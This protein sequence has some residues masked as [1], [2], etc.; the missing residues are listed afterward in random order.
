M[1]E[2][3][4]YG[5]ED[6]SRQ[7]CFLY[8][9]FFQED[10]YAISHDHYLDGSSSS[11]PMEHLSSNDQFS[12]LTVKRLIGQIR[13]QNHS[14]VLFVN[15]A[16]NPLADC[17][18][19]SY[20]ESV[21]EGLTLVLEVPFSIRSKYSV[22]GMN[23]WKSFRSIH[24]IFPFLEDKFPHSNY[25]SDARIP[26]SI[27]P[28]ILV[29]TFR[30]LIR[31]APSLHPLRSVLYEYRNS[32]ENLQRSIIVVPRVN[33]RFFLFLWNYYVYECESILFS[34]LKRSSHSRSLA[35]RPFPHGTHFHRKIKH[36]IIFSRRNSLKSIW[37]L[38]DPKINYVRYGE[39]SIIAIKGTHLLVKKCRYYLLL[40][41]QCYFHL[42]SE[43]YRVCSHQLSKNCSSSLG[44]FLRVRMNPLFVRTK[45]L[46]ELFIA[47]L[48]TNEFDPIVPIVP[49][50]GL[51]AREKFCDVSGRPISKLSW[52]NLTDDDILNRFDQIWR[53]LF[54]YYSGSFG[55]DGLYRIKYILS[56]SCAKTL[57]CKHK[58][59]I[60][61]VR[62]ELGPELLSKIVFK[63]TRFDSLP[64]S[65]KAAARSQRER[66]WHSD[67]PQ[68]NPLV[69]SWQKIQDLKIENL[70][71]Q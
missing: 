33:T 9:L 28:E 46:D 57:A 49:I 24:S 65:S 48:I 35:H 17:K 66:I 39:R 56:L 71:D 14:I 67:I 62:K 42:W 43:P 58:S 31:D 34:L 5:K 38:K 11:E 7:Q 53:N 19:S 36:I 52:T 30:R 10:L 27:H 6:N 22:E 8:P 37:L 21:L 50:L 25:I 13:Q 1:D 51:L 68:I 15:C 29:R 32:P 16:P 69:N 47:D 64:F 41:R 70:F 44:Y 23:E 18:K 61:V 12:F 59:T 55:R 40:F 4:R 3:H 63:R 45:M 2:F 60:R 54:H 20:S 26:Y